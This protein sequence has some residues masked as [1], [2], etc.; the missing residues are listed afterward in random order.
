MAVFC[1]LLS[2]MFDSH[3]SNIALFSACDV[4]CIN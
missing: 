2:D 4:W 1:H 3:I